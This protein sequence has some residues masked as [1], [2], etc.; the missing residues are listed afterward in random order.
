M[1]W[2]ARLVCGYE[3]SKHIFRALL[4]HSQGASQLGAAF[5]GYYLAEIE[6]LIL[7]IYKSLSERILLSSGQETV[8]NQRGLIE[9]RIVSKRE[10]AGWRGGGVAGYGG[11][12]KGRRKNT[13]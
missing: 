6:S 12:G 3:F 10:V 1:E 2:L 7:E 4:A 5:V 9:P 8:P 11:K 13:G